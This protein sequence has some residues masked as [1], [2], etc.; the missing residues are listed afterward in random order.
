MSVF[1]ALNRL[2]NRLEQLVG[3]PCILRERF[4]ELEI[5][6]YAILVRL[7]MVYVQHFK[8]KLGMSRHDYPVL[9]TWLKILYWTVPGFRE[10][11]DSRHIKDD[12]SD[13]SLVYIVPIRRFLFSLMVRELYHLSICSF[14]ETRVILRTFPLHRVTTLY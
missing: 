10:S 12:V 7:D 14:P 5:R 8:C 1:G 6:V 3:G 4:T 9:N 2:V 11:T 13:M